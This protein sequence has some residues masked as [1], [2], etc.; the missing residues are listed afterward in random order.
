[1][2]HEHRRDGHRHFGIGRHISHY[3]GQDAGASH[4]AAG[5]GADSPAEEYPAVAVAGYGMRDGEAHAPVPHGLKP[6]GA[7]PVAEPFDGVER[8]AVLR[9]GGLGDLLFA[10]PAIEALAAAYPQAEI[11]LLGTPLHAELLRGRPGPVSRVEVLPVAEGVRPPRRGQ[12]EDP[13]ATGRFL[14]RMSK[15][16]FDLALQLHGGG[17]FSNPFLRR[18]G[19]RHMVGMQTPDAEPLERNLPYTYYQHE[20]LRALE[21]AGLAGAVP[22][23]LEPR[24]EPTPG[25]L[26]AAAGLVDDGCAGLLTL[27]PGATDPRRR[28]PPSHFA[29]VAALA[30]ADGCQVLV[31]GDD[32]D[33]P[34]AVEIVRLARQQGGD[35]GGSIRSLAGRLELG[36]LAGLLALSDVMVGNDSGPRHLAQAVGTATVGVYWIGNV[37]NAAPLGR[38]RHRIQISWLTHCPV[39]G[40]D[41]TQIGWTAERCP[42]DFSCVDSVQ[43]EAVYRDVADLKATTVLPRAR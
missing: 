29:K 38:G 6:Q 22:V 32:G 16:G 20:V 43:P 35:G 36:E 21:V 13:D 9:G 27:H 37:I 23:T 8:I 26:A 5:H 41:C 40:A 14:D 3:A 25:E 30:A 19:A 28:W 15:Q 34:A 18:L 17:R 7:G 11:T 12:T 42:H 39:C 31:V 33:R 1:M 4:E 10:M 2:S 24:L